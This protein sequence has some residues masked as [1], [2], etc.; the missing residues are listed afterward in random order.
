MVPQETFLFS[1]TIRENIA[2]GRPDA[3]REEVLEA[4][5]LAGLTPD[6]AGFPQGLDTIVGERGLTLSGG[7]KQRVALARALLREPRILLLDDCLSAVDTQTEEAHP[8][9]PADRLLGRTV[10]LVSHRI[11][12]VKDGEP[13]PGPRPGAHRRARHPRAA[14]RRRRPLRRAPPAPAAGRG[15][16]GRSRSAAG[17]RSM[18]VV[19]TGGSGLIGSAL[20]RELGSSG[21]EVV[22]LTRDPSRV[23]TCRRA[24][25]PCS[26]TARPRGGGAR[27]ST[28]TRRSSISPARAIAAGR[29]TDEKKRRIRRE[30]RR[31]G[32]GGAGG[33][34]ARR[35][36]KPRVLLQGSA[37]GYYGACGDEVVERGPPAGQR[38]PGR[39]SASNGRPRRPRSEALGVRRPVLRTGDRAQPRGRGPAARWRSPSG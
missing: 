29:W 10:F 25:A 37:V 31:V 33:A 23:G 30:P 20:A 13:D 35:R 38:L 1:A 14:H 6:L 12:T 34:S 27:C 19:I 21:H 39:A 16:G 24:R 9:Q 4:A 3:T 7:Q 26:G 11:S 8:R 15:A 18:R 5:R 32:P 22:V 36:S 2:L 28:R 17:G